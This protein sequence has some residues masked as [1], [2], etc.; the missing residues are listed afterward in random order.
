LAEHN[1]QSI[2]RRSWKQSTVWQI[3]NSVGIEMANGVSRKGDAIIS[4]KNQ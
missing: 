3:A 1:W 4:K 2:W